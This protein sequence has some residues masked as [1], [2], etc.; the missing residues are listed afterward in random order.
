MHSTAFRSRSRAAGWSEPPFKT[1]EHNRTFVQLLRWSAELVQ[2]KG[3]TGNTRPRLLV[4]R[5]PDRALCYIASE[6]ANSLKARRSNGYT[7][8]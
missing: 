8:G 3:N 7:I 5:K 2:T 1:A 6:Q 4:A